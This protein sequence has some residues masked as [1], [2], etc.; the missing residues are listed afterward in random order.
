AIIDKIVEC[1]KKGQ[2]VLV[3]TV[4]IDKSEIL[5]AL[6]SKRGIP[7]NVL[8]AKLHA[9]EAEIVAQ[10]GKF[11]AVTISTNMAGRG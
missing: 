9:K 3:G 5:S 8:N 6:L 7:H 10:A 11:G 2:P 1:H 4:S